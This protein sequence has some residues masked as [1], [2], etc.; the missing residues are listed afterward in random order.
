MDKLLSKMLKKYVIYFFNPSRFGLVAVCKTSFGIRK[1]IHFC[2]GLSWDYFV[3]VCC[4]IFVV[5]V[6]TF[7]CVCVCV[8]LCA[9]VCVVRLNK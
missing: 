6:F 2:N 1:T 9:I 8:F 3:F 7:V 5:F 4:C